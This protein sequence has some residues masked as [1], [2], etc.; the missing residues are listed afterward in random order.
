MINKSNQN[1]KRLI[2]HLT[3][4]YGWSLVNFCLTYG[5]GA[6]ATESTQEVGRGNI[7]FMRVANPSWGM[8]LARQY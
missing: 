2:K 1:D 7:S 5:H 4:L 6:K 3:L 8:R